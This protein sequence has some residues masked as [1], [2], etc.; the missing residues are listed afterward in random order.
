M[1]HF[2]EGIHFDY[3]LENAIIG[4]CVLM[5]QN[6]PQVRLWVKTSEIF[7]SAFNRL[8]FDSMIDLQ[9]KNERIDMITLKMHILGL[10]KKKLLGFTFASNEL[11]YEIG[12]VCQSV[13]SGAHLQEWCM[14]LIQFYIKRIQIDHAMNIFNV[15]DP[16]K[17]SV[18]LKD[19]I[20][21]AMSFNA[22]KEWST[23]EDIFEELK[24]RRLNIQEGLMVGVK[25]GF[26]E[27]DRILGG[28]LETG[29]HVICARPGMGKTAFALSLAIN[30]ATNMD[31][32]GIISL[33]MPNVQLASRIITGLSGVPFMSVFKGNPQSSPFYSEMI[34]HKIEETFV[35]HRNLPI[36][37]SD[38]T[39]VNIN[40]IRFKATKLKNDKNAKAIFIDYLQLVE[41]QEGR[42]EQRHTAVGKLSRELKL[43]SKE[44]DMPI[45]ALAQLNRESESADKVSKIGKVSQL[46]ESGSIEQDMDMGIV[47]D[48]PFKRGMHTNENGEGTERVGIIDVQ[49]HRNGE[50]ATIQVEFDPQTMRFIDKQQNNPF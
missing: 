29:F 23:M 11:A 35:Q 31:V 10:E 3:E 40:D 20:N 39:K 43:L 30:M 4:I 50:E 38:Q 41:I 14:I 18:I 17:A 49:K 7:Y 12:K 6:L 45:V 8:L 32:V 48:R 46:R 37:I 9:E 2:K 47:I 19:K 22:G 5:P 36:F 42:N 33:E 16:M 13:V 21:Y 1:Q 44:L 27:L 24:E 26:N 28:G 25:T 15:D 34:E